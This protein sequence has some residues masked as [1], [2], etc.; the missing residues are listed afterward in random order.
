MTIPTPNPGRVLLGR[1][2]LCGHWLDS[3]TAT[4]VGCRPVD[5]AVREA[6]R[7]HRRPW[8]VLT[9]TEWQAD[10]MWRAARAGVA[11]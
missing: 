5:G 1:C 4:R 9:D 6:H 3:P 11:A 7:N 2:S 8:Q 10:R